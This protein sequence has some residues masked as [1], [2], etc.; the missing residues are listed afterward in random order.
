M[1]KSV[2]IGMS[3]GVDSSVAAA[4][5]VQNG[6]DVIGVTMKLWDEEGQVTDSMCCSLDAVNDAKR[7][8][9]I[10]GIPHYVFNFKEEF[11]TNVINYFIREYTLGHTPNPCIACNKHIKFD[12]FLKKAQAMGIDYIATGHYAK[13]ELCGETGRWLLKRSQAVLKD[14]TYVLYGMTQ[15]QIEHT[16]FPLGDFEKKD[17]VRK[18]AE[19]LGLKVANKPESQEICFVDGDY[20]YYIESRQ[21]GISK[22]GS[23]VDTNGKVLGR[24]K[25][26][27]HYT[28][29]QR[30]GLGVALGKPVFVTAI[31]TAKNQV[32]LGD[33]NE[34]FTDELIAG[35]VNLIPFEKL[36]T[37]MKLTAKIRYSAKEAKACISPLSNGQI[38]V[39]FEQKQRAVTPGQAVVFYQGDIVVGGGTIV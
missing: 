13:T 32:V 26:I 10:I 25:G 7:V 34:I 8:A 3:G 35:D 12:L 39:K 21:T 28:I 4:L 36:E 38:K 16:L 22:P 15:Q 27:V 6:Y 9:D 24:H 2:M 14:Q 30:K 19:E 11:Q 31:D 37:E 33:E 17:E 5:L 1:K 20:G 23:F 29:G 18:I